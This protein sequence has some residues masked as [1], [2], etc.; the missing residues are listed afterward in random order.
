MDSKQRFDKAKECFEEIQ[1]EAKNQINRNF[2]PGQP[3][4]PVS[5]FALNLSVGLLELTHALE[6]ELLQIRGSLE[7]ISK[8]P[9]RVK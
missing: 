4:D 1:D 6:T 8:R 5:A 9:R 3:P 7:A 2:Q